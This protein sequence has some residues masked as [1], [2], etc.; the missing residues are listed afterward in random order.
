MM[1]AS[2]G[3]EGENKLGICKEQRGNKC[4]AFSISKQWSA[5]GRERLRTGS[6]CEAPVGCLATGC[7]SKEM[8]W[9]NCSFLTLHQ[10]RLKNEVGI[11]R[12]AALACVRLQTWAFIAL[13]WRDGLWRR[14]VCCC[15]SSQEMPPWC[16]PLPLLAPQRSFCFSSSH[17]AQGTRRHL[18]ACRASPW[19]ASGPCKGSAA[20]SPCQNPVSIPARGAGW[21][22]QGRPVRPASPS[23]PRHS[24]VLRG[25]AAWRREAG[26]GAGLQSR[27]GSGLTALFP[28]GTH[29]VV[30]LYV[31]KVH[32]GWGAEGELQ[33]Q[34]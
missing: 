10:S 31:L 34:S 22:P 30:M 5:S 20:A 8:R 1:D 23:A 17:V 24:C 19:A 4:S 6:P 21:V 9:K 11:S 32:M 28:W 14:A 16:L 3:L 12:E 13:W 15:G 27:A 33:C 2:Q 29:S 7:Q 18:A 26:E 25:S